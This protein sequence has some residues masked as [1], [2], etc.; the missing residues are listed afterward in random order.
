MRLLV[1]SA[2]VLA[3]GSATAAAQ[4]GQG[5]GGGMGGGMRLA[6]EDSTF[7]PTIPALTSLLTLTPEQV[8]EITPLR[9][10]MLAETKTARQEGRSARA[11]MQEARQAGV[12]DDSLNVLRQKMRSIM[13][14]M[15]P[16]RKKFL[17][18]IRPLLTGDQLKILDAR[19]QEVMGAMRQ[20]MQGAQPS[21]P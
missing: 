2:I 14:G 9:D 8:K 5:T 20:G 21:G 1:L 11:A 17:N 16:A 10:T 18:E 4:G 3:A 19:E 12:N 15:M 7:R 6:L 13:M